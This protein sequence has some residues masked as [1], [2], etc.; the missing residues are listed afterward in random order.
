MVPLV[1]C[2]STNFRISS[3]SFWFNGS[4]QAGKVAGAFG[5]NLMAWS[6]IVQC[7]MVKTDQR[8]SLGATSL[9]PLQI[10]M[11][12]FIT[13]WIW[14]RIGLPSRLSRSNFVILSLSDLDLSNL[15]FSCH[16]T[17]Y[18]NTFYLWSMGDPSAVH[19]RMGPQGS[20]STFQLLSLCLLLG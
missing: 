20:V 18:K 1:R 4:R 5:N 6:Q 8:H 14:C 16:N 19:N 12:V 7:E 13:Q 2:S 11:Y 10:S 15:D 9:L 17:I 3:C